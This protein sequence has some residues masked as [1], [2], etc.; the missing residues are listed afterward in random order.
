MD[1]L[2][3]CVM[4][5]FR[6]SGFDMYYRGSRLLAMG[7]TVYQ[8]IKTKSPDKPVIIFVADRYVQPPQ[9]P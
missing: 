8:A 6:P 1:A 5:V 2:C 4:C 3:V 9:P 7:K